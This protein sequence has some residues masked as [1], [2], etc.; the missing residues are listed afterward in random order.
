M[1][2][3]KLPWNTFEQDFLSLYSTKGRQAKPVRLMVGLL[4]LKQMFNVSDEQLI[5]QWVQNPYWQAFCGMTR[6]QWK[7][8]CDPSDLTYFRKRIGETG[9]QQIFAASIRI[10]GQTAQEDEV[11]VDTTVQEKNIAFPTD[12]RLQ[13]K[14]IYRCIK[15]AAAEGITL[16]R[17]YG[18]KLKAHIRDVRFGNGKEARKRRRDAQQAIK[19]IANTL[20]RELERKLSSAAIEKHKDSLTLYSKAVNQAKN[21]KHKIYSLD[22]PE[23]QCIAKGKEHKK[24]EFGAKASVAVGSKHG[25]I[26][27][28]KSFEDNIH[29]SR[30]LPAVVDQIREVRGKNPKVL[31][32]DRG[33]R[34]GDPGP[35]IKLVIPE[36]G[37]GKKESEKHRAKTRFRRRSKVEAVIGHLKYGYRLLRNYLKG[38]VGDAINLMLAATAYNCK[39]WMRE[40]AARPLF[41]FWGSV[42]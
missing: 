37:K 6:F 8:P 14:V 26:V 25:V 28:A 31:I 24:Y 1:L 15:I 5:A 3:F 32:A 38:T 22:K 40:M 11:I 23:T 9:V 7:A 29:D 17:S 16:R 35:E 21:D 19:K 18:R 36:T 27:G 4:L 41:I 42:T 12:T 39:K 20:L 13:L 2:S 30:T 10:H 33:Y 34:G